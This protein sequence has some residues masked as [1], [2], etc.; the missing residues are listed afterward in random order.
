MENTVNPYLTDTQPFVDQVEYTTTDENDN[1]LTHKQ[2]LLMMPAVIDSI[3]LSSEPLRLKNKAKTP[4]RLATV[5]VFNPVTQKEQ[6][7]TAQLFEAS[8]LRHEDTFVKGG[9]VRVAIQTEGEYKGYAKLQLA[10]LERIDTDAIT[11]MLAESKKEVA[12]SA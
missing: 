5:K 4:W 12:Q 2:S 8:R 6:K 11:A 3:P 10:T 1:T 7:I 9:E